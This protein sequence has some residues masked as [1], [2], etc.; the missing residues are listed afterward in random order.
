MKMGITAIDEPIKVKDKN[1]I[2]M[3]LEGFDAICDEE[4]N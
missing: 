3:N 2:I 4:S 1:Y